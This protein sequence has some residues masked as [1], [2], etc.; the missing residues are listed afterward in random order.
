MCEGLTQAKVDANGL[1]GGEGE[2]PDPK[3]HE[4]VC[5]GSEGENGQPASL[6]PPPPVLTHP[7]LTCIIVI[8]HQQ[9]PNGKAEEDEMEKLICKGRGEDYCLLLSL[10]LIN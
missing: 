8:T 7:P 1:Q 4:P 6:D 9:G 5:R 3:G 2:Q 10:F